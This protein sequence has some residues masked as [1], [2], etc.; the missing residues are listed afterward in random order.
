M[1]KFKIQKNFLK[2]IKKKVKISE[3]LYFLIL[4]NKELKIIKRIILLS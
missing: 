4:I 3:N 2:E 1:Y